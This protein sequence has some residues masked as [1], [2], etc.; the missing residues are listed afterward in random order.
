[1]TA[2]RR[3]LLLTKIGACPCALLLPLTAMFI[4]FSPLRRLRTLPTG[5]L[6]AAPS[7]EPARS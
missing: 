4:V 7:A 6:A 5:D 1:M 2:A 3:A